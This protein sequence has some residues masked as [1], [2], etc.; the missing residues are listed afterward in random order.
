MIGNAQAAAPAQ[1]STIAIDGAVLKSLN[2][3]FYV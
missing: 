1:I 3:R 2:E